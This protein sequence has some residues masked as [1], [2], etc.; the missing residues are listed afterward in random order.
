MDSSIISGLFGGV[1]ALII[2]S[3]V[4]KKTKNKK[5][6][7]QLRHSKLLLWLFFLSLAICLFAFG[8]LFYDDSI[9][10]DNAELFSVIG[11]V[12][13]FG[14]CA[15][16]SFGEYSNVK[17]SFDQQK[18]ALNTPWTSNKE[19][20]WEDLVSIQFNAVMYWYTLEF[21]SGAKIRLSSYLVGLG[22]VLEILKDRGYDF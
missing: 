20:L 1:A 13:G 19:E 21:K 12:I 9:Y 3:F 7:G 2:C 14:G 18:I 16:Y 22:Q 11:L 4:I 8:A 5:T 17:G 10:H 6:N 15:I